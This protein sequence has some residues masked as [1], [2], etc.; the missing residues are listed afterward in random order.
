[1]KLRL[2]TTLLLVVGLAVAAVSVSVTTTT[3]PAKAAP[4]RQAWPDQHTTARR[5]STDNVILKWNEQLLSAIRAYPA[6]TGPTITARAL[7]V[8]HTATYDAWAAYD[9]TAKVT[10]PDGPTQQQASRTLAANKNKAIS[11]AAYRVLNDLFPVPAYA[12]PARRPAAPIAAT[13]PCW[14]CAPRRLLTSLATTRQHHAGHPHAAATPPGSATSPPR[15][16]WT[17]ATATAQ[18]SSA[19]TPTARRVATPTRPATCPRTP[20]TPSP[21]P[22][23]GSPCASPSRTRDSPAPA[24]SRSR[25]RRSGATSRCSGRWRRPASG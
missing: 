19:T 12:C 13:N 11:Y 23:T 5:S 22:G 21:T 25:P 20:G 6:Q 10:R 18:T 1:M 14:L 3:P 17:T 16:C 24:P 8:L 15:P 9:P 7:G 2:A 4:G